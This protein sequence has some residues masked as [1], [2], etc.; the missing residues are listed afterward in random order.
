MLNRQDCA[1]PVVSWSMA[2]HPFLVSS[3]LAGIPCRYDGNARPDAEIIAAVENGH[4]VP[5]CAEQLGGLPTPRPAA[6]IR[7]GDGSDVLRGTAAVI[8]D[9]GEDVTAEFIAGAEKVTE[10]ALAHGI[11][12]AVL[13]ARSPSC[14]CGVVYDGSHSGELTRGDGVLAAMLTQRGITVRAVR[15]NRDTSTADENAGSPA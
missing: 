14:G 4:A 3:C 1:S 9:Q 7:G 6:E 2:A 15:G 12:E 13:Q 10:L 11:T 5:A 8:T